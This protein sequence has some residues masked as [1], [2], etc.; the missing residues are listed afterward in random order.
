MFHNS[1]QLSVSF[2]CFL[3]CSIFRVFIGILR[4]FHGVWTFFHEFPQ[5]F[6]AFLNYR[7]IC[8]VIHFMCC[9]CFPMFFCTFQPGPG[10]S[11]TPAVGPWA[12]SW[13]RLAGFGIR[14]VKNDNICLTSPFSAAFMKGDV[15]AFPWTSMDF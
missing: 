15:N 2:L 5:L 14:F 4:I 13:G 10:T 1:C 8:F 7:F 3:F 6:I 11:G 12:V 9:F